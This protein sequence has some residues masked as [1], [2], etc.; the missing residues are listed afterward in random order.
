MPRL[1]GSTAKIL[2]RRYHAVGPNIGRVLTCGQAS[3]SAASA[4]VQAFICSE[5]AGKCGRGRA[6]AF[7]FDEARE[8][9]RFMEAGCHP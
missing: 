2:S 3:S 9:R 7:P 4:A 8:A 1:F 6:D 5:M